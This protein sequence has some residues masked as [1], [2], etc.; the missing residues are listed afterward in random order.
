MRWWPRRSRVWAAAYL[1]FAVYH[2]LTEQ[3]RS[4][5][6]YRD[7]CIPVY[8]K[9]RRLSNNES[10]GRRFCG[11]KLSNLVAPPEYKIASPNS[12]PTLS[13]LPSRTMS[14]SPFLLHIKSLWQATTVNTTHQQTQFLE[15]QGYNHYGSCQQPDTHTELDNLHVP[16]EAPIKGEPIVQTSY[17][18]RSHNLLRPRPPRFRKS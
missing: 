17:R 3:W 11:Y 5:C 7:I 12:S 1:L 2:S 4:P 16:V 15:S 9:W 13:L 10:H 18:T 8:R 6:E 14:A